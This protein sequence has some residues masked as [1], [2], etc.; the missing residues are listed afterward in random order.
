[1]LERGLR[2]NAERE[3]AGRQYVVF[4]LKLIEVLHLT[5]L[6][7]HLRD[8][9]TYPPNVL[10]HGVTEFQET[11]LGATINAFMSIADKQTSTNARAIWKQLY[12]K[13]AKAIDRVWNR[14]IS[15]GESLM[16][17][18]RDRAGVHGD[19]PYKYFAAKLGLLSNTEQ[20]LDALDAFHGLSV[21]L[22]KRL[23]KEL[24][25]LSSEIEKTLLDIELKLDFPGSFN[26]KWLRKMHLT[27]SGNYTKKFL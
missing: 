5:L 22:L 12:P 9:G 13:H 8:T 1:M 24:P 18:Y 6:S 19:A 25:E 10:G 4:H 7:V 16:K 11:L 27:E 20:V 26:R 17:S 15:S 23:R 21:C 2:M 3:K 14:R